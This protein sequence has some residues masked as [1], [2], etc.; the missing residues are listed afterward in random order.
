VD[1][2]FAPGN[3]LRKRVDP[4]TVYFSQERTEPETL[5]FRSVYWDRWLKKKPVTLALVA[6]LPPLPDMTGED[7]RVLY[8]DLTKDKFFARPVFVEIEPEKISRVFSLP[9][10]PKTNLPAKSRRPDNRRPAARIHN[11]PESPEA[12]VPPEEPGNG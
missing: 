11:D 2:Y 9:R 4:F 10:D 6:D 7:P 8:I 3:A 12:P 1:A 5:P